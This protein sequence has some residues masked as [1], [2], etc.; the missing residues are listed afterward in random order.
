MLTKNEERN[1]VEC[2]QSVRWAKQIILVDAKSTDQTVKLAKRFTKD[3]FVRP[4][5][6]FGEAKNFALSKVKNEWVLWLDADERVTDELRNEIERL[7]SEK[8]SPYVAY[9][10]PRKAIFLGKWIR[11]CGWYPGRVIRLFRRGYG[12]FTT[13]K[14]HEQLV[15]RGSIG[16]LNGDLLHYTDP[17][18][19]HYFQK[20]NRYTS[21]AAEELDDRGRQ[22]HVYDILLRP[23]WTFFRM[24]FLKRGFF[25]G[26]QGFVLCVLSSCYVFTKYAKLWE[27]KHTKSRG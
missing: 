17:N 9:D 6:G 7:V 25:D 18:L 27:L 8:L 15:V 20:F 3:I 26:F 5:D 13:S 4:W 22:F 21:L 12:S 11:H 23:A 14:V 19:E 10:I 1:I 24:Y 2:L 16:H